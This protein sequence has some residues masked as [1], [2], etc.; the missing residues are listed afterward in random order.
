MLPVEVSL[1]QKIEELFSYRRFEELYELSG[2]SQDQLGLLHSNLKKL[3][4]SIYLLDA[5]LEDNWKLDELV[6]AQRWSEIY[7]NLEA[8]AIDSQAAPAY[9]GHIRRYEKH[10]KQ[11]RSHIL[12]SKYSM[13]YFYFYK[14]CDVKLMRRLIFEQLPQLKKLFSLPEWRWFDLITE[15]NDDVADLFEDI[16]YINGNSFLIGLVVKGKKE[17]EKTFLDFINYIENKNTESDRFK[18]EWSQKIFEMTKE[19]IFLTKQL[20][21][22]NLDTFT[23]EDL[24]KS[25]LFIHFNHSQ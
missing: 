15:V 21:K 2:A 14:S 18:S 10:E 17:T 11:L 9:C 6:L 3:Q 23:I 4:T 22:D 1:D 25:A 12:P 7:K 5:H 8:F 20:L 16:D 19:N 13:E 24:N